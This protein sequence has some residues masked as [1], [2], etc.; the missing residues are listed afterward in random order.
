MS[1]QQ[2]RVFLW[3]VPRSIST[4]FFRA[5]MNKTNCKVLLE[6]YSRAYYFGHERVSKRYGT[7]PEQD[8]CAY[9]DIKAMCEQ[10][11]SEY[12]TVFVKDMAYY[13]INRL[14]TP[15][16]IPDNYIHAFLLRDPHKSVYSLYK[17]SLNKDLTGWDHFEANEVG[18]KELYQMFRLVTEQVGQ[19]PI[20]IDADDLLK[21]PE[22]TFRLFC[23][24]VS[25]QFEDRMLNWEDTPQ[26]L[27]VFQEWMP[28]FEGVLTTNT[29]QP[30]AT[31]PKSP[32]NI[33]AIDF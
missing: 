17:M 15:A 24:K 13:L 10:P 21:Q 18:F 31:K 22:T 20:I 14:D 9:K 6:P 19:E 32:I 16:Y 23:E 25:L 12:E 2:V 29:F 30:S 27:A 26:D 7:E 1:K 28:W 3:A 33:R 8:G 4:A 11:Y 5:M